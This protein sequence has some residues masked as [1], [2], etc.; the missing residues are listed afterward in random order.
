MT[1]LF[2]TRRQQARRQKRRRFYI[3]LA[4][5]LIGGAAAG[6][7]YFGR[8]SVISKDADLYAQIAELESVRDG[9]N[10]GLRIMQ[11]EI[12]RTTAEKGLV[13]E[14]YNQDVPP[15]AL[16]PLVGQL[17][18]R[19]DDGM[20]VDRLAFVLENLSAVDRCKRIEV[21]RFR[22]TT[23]LTPQQGV[24]DR[25]SFALGAV[26]ITATGQPADDELGNPVAWYNP[27]ERVTVEFTLVDGRIVE[28]DGA[29]PINDRIVI[30]DREH[31]FIFSEGP[32]SFLLATHQSCE[33]P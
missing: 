10:E 21:K 18:D 28:T 14:L 25:V 6:G 4:L 31:R 27:A 24:D 9:L 22:P 15:P 32:R 1:G 7:F 12:D 16:R 30:G 20:A 17:K 11:V 3:T 5:T 26:Q 13:E 23:R 19:I 2:E 33:F 8:E 29:L